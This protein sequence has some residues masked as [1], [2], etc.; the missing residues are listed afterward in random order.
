[1]PSQMAPGFA[2]IEVEERGRFPAHLSASPVP[3]VMFVRTLVTV[4]VAPV[5]EGRGV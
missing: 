2:L 5:D 1:M 3:G 4:R